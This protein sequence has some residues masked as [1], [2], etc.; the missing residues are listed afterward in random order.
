MLAGIAIA[1]ALSVISVFRRAWRPYQTVLGRVDGLPGYHDLRSYPDAEVLPGLVV[2]RFD[3]PLFF[4]NARTFRDQIRRLA[5]ADPPPTWIIV[6]AEPITDIDTTAADMLEDLDQRINAAGVSLVFAEM[7]DPV[8]EKIERY[9]LTR[10]IDPNHFFPTVDGSRRR[11]PARNRNRVGARL[12][13]AL[14]ASAE[15]LHGRE[16]HESDADAEQ[17]SSD[18]V[19]QPVHLEVGSAPGH[20]GDTQGRDRPPQTAAWPEGG[21]EENERDARGAGVG[22]MAGRKGRTG[23]VDEPVGRAG[24]VDVRLEQRREQRCE[25]LRDGEREQP[26]PSTCNE[27]DDADRRDRERP[28]DAASEP[29]EDEREVLQGGRLDVLH[30]LQPGALEGERLCR[31]EDRGERDERQ[32]GRSDPQRATRVGEVPLASPCRG[33][34]G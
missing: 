11:L 3:A 31:N 6:A 5:S 27:E 22:G 12:E 1:V 7:K 24:A 17:R 30:R 8:R 4:A 29:V 25:R 9:E 26:E 13:E 33:T 16:C 18:Y 28:A 15:L 23:R 2:F 34:C 10:T 32:Q 20:A 14:T 19:D 21:E